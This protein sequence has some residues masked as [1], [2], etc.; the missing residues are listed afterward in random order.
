MT[1]QENTVL[2]HELT[3]RRKRDLNPEPRTQPLQP[4]FASESLLA[5]LLRL[6]TLSPNYNKTLSSSSQVLR[7][8]VSTISASSSS[9][10]SSAR[11]HHVT[12]HCSSLQDAPPVS[13][14][15]GYESSGDSETTGTRRLRGRVD[16]FG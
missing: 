16:P 9:P 1:M 11:I 6:R 7:N 10:S 8:V 2:G 15:G 4:P 5:Q 3:E 12:P 13:Y 14:D